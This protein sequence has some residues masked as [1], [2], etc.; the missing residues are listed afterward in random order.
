MR[1]CS[2]LSFLSL[3]VRL[4]QISDNVVEMSVTY[5]SVHKGTWE[6]LGCGNTRANEGKECT[7]EFTPEID[8]EPP[9]LIYY[10]IDNFYQ[11]HQ[12]YITSRDD[13]Q[14]SIIHTDGLKSVNG[15]KD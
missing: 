2:T 4:K 10:E 14:V 15:S 9:V 3:G 8:M 13:N 1:F 11:N 12:S 6:D 7:I 5:D